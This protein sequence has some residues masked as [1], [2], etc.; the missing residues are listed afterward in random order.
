[1]AREN[2]VRLFGEITAMEEQEERMLLTVRV[3]R[4]N[5]DRE[6]FVGVTVPKNHEDLNNLSVGDYVDV[7]GIYTTNEL[8]QMLV[9]P[10][11]GDKV[12]DLTFSS[13]VFALYMRKYPTRVNLEDH[14][15]ISNRVYLMGLVSGKVN[16]MTIQS[17]DAMEFDTTRYRM[18]VKRKVRIPGATQDSDKPFVS[19]FGEQAVTDS[20]RLQDGC[21]VFINGSIQSRNIHV[22][23][24][25]NSCN[26]ILSI[27][28][29]IMEVVP[30][31]VEYLKGARS[32]QSLKY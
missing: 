31:G 3:L 24:S 30:Q 2:D 29:P 5:R 14:R 16:T 11:C 20:M 26:H 1:M 8:E 25:C 32:W 23:H 18:T 28:K 13:S 6:D 22:K 9:C 7:Q 17:S 15:E 27:E 4:R 19:S 12:K 10:E 21:L